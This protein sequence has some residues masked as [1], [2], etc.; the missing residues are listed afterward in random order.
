[1]GSTL[2]LT[3]NSAT[4]P[5]MKSGVGETPVSEFDPDAFSESIR[6]DDVLKYTAGWSAEQKN[7]WINWLEQA[8]HRKQLAAVN[9]HPAM[10]AQR[11][12]PKWTLT[13]A[14]DL[15]S[16][17][18]ADTCRSKA[19]RLL[20]S[21]PPQEGKALPACGVIL[22]MSVTPETQLPTPTKF[23]T[24]EDIRPGDIVFHP[25]G[26]PIKV[27]A[28]TPIQKDRPMFRVT[29]SDD[30]TVVVD[31]QHLW[32][33]RDLRRSRTE[34]GKSRRGGPW[35]QKTTRELMTGGLERE[36]PRVRPSGTVA[37]AYRYTLPRQYLIDSPDH[38][39]LPIPPYVFGLW[40][41]DGN[42]DGPRITE[43][44]DDADELSAN[45]ERT[46]VTIRSRTCMLNS[47][48]RAALLYLQLGERGEF[49]RTLRDLG[50]FQNK[51]IPD[52][53]LTAGTS[54]RLELLRGLLD[55]DGAISTNGST[56][57]VEYSSCRERLSE[58]VLYLARSLGWRAKINQSSSSLD[59][60]RKQDRYRV[61][62]TPTTDD[63]N[64]FHL[65]RKAERVQADKSRGGERHT[66]N[67]T[68]I[69]PA[70]T[71]NAYCIQVD[72][73][74]GLFLAGRDLVPTHNSTLTS[75]VGSLWALQ[76]NPDTRVMI[77]AN[78]DSLAMKMAT[79]AR[80]WV[81]THGAE[82]TEP[83]TGERMP[84]RLGFSL[85]AEKSAGGHWRVKG[86][87]GG[88]YSAGVGGNIVGRPADLMVI[89]DPFK[90]W[91]EADSPLRRSQIWQWWE[92]NVKPRLAP[93]APVIVVMTR[94]HEEDL[95]GQL[96]LTGDWEVINIPAISEPE[97]PD[98][99]GR[100]PGV[101]MESAR[102]GRDFFEVLR[103]YGGPENRTW[104]AQYMGRTP[105]RMILPAYV[106][107]WFNTRRNSSAYAAY[108]IVP[109]GNAGVNR[110]FV[111]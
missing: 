94:W 27:I 1:M 28:K 47:R 32:T 96:E 82:A 57:R 2:H 18:Y 77:T 42:S 51:H 74:D 88:I 16:H 22:G 33:V 44:L 34:N 43:G 36:P 110:S 46:G 69:E 104:S 8:A 45:I 15:I 99:L 53:Y 81:S 71:S 85:A 29:T 7:A 12:D 41:A 54:Q 20:V 101:Q 17:K 21:M 19:G 97:V 109:T 31:E 78:A 100:D 83:I 98:A 92:G 14:L 103:G 59:G 56:Y 5:V 35:E 24:V 58:G 64:P 62:F 102:E 107:C 95:A 4:T 3:V 50:V 6:P 72:S 10:L 70:G 76:Q 23:L 13:P 38:T 61:T 48:G 60:E 108:S 84:D 52:V 73:P 65:T 75:V 55:G 26:H 37:H 87:K 39:D 106:I 40:L 90:S 9:T 68:S 105:S 79:E 67:I 86:H 66:V 91:I 49:S 111:S 30:R 63:P 25:D 80:D 89:D 11:L 93:H